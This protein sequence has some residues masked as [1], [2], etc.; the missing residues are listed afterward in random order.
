MSIQ[1]SAKVDASRLCETC[2]QAGAEVRSNSSN[3]IHQTWSTDFSRSLIIKGTSKCLSKVVRI[4]RQNVS[5]CNFFIQ[6]H[7]IWHESLLDS[8]YNISGKNELGVL[9]EG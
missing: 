1:R 6:F 9:G 3:K 2:R 7:T 8:L 5:D 4:F